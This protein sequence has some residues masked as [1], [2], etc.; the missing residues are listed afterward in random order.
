[1]LPV[2]TVD[3]ARAIGLGGRVGTLT[4]GARADVILVGGVAHLTA[5]PGAVA[6]AVVT[7]LGPANVRTVLVDG[8]VVKRDGQLIHSG[9]HELR[10]AATE[11]ARRALRRPTTG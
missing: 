10:A 3:S 7:T 11:L 9:L 1:M 2:A 4:A 5:T 8:Q 6:G